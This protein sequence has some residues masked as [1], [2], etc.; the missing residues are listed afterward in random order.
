MRILNRVF[1][2]PY[3]WLKKSNALD[4]LEH[5]DDHVR[6]LYTILP[7]KIFIVN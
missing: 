3:G 2:C 4:R 5:E 6:V 7:H 1:Q